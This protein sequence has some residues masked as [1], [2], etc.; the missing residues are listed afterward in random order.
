MEQ[1][2]KEETSVGSDRQG[3]QKGVG[4]SEREQPPRTNGRGSFLFPPKDKMAEP[5]IQDRT[6]SC[7]SYVTMS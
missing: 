4:V 7:S 2:V 1:K 5:I 6:F 3:R